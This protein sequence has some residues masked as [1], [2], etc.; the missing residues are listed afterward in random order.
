MKKLLSPFVY[1]SNNWLSL[2]GVV[3]VTTATIL[4]LCLLPVTLRGEITHPYA[5]I[6]IYFVLPGIFF[7]GLFL[8]PVGILWK[9]RRQRSA[10]VY[11]ESFPPL[12][13][14]NHELRRLLAF[15]GVT[16][17]INVIISSQ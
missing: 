14:K 3:I 11:P 2:I 1:F 9:R 13:F 15:I 6:I 5:G 12:D 10:G 4:W 17:I 8:I 16:T 7:A